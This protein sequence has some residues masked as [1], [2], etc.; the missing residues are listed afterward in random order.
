MHREQYYVVIPEQSRCH[1][2]IIENIHTFCEIEIMFIIWPLCFQHILLH[3]KSIGKL[4]LGLCLYF[5]AVC[6]LKK[7]FALSPKG[8]HLCVLLQLGEK[9]YCC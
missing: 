6:H 7:N 9:F 3:E 4:E 8:F 5:L 2:N 1:F